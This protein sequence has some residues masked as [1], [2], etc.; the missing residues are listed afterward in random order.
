[1]HQP[2][3]V[4]KFSSLSRRILARLQEGSFLCYAPG[5]PF[6]EEEV[7][8]MNGFTVMRHRISMHMPEVEE[9]AYSTRILRIES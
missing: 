6:F 4:G 1:L 3:S 5:M 7:E 2:V 9:I 8:K